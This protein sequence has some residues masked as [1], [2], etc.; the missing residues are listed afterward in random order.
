MRTIVDR[1]EG[2]GHSSYALQVL[3]YWASD[4]LLIS[5]RVANYVKRT[6][7]WQSAVLI[8]ATLDLN[9]MS[10]TFLRQFGR[11]CGLLD[12]DRL[13]D[14][15]REAVYNS[16]VDMG[17]GE[18]L[19][20][21]H[22]SWEDEDEDS[23]PEGEK[24]FDERNKSS[25]YDD[26][27]GFR[28][29]RGDDEY[30][31]D[32]GLQDNIDDGEVDLSMHSGIRGASDASTM[33]Q[34]DSSAD[35]DYRNRPRVRSMRQIRDLDFGRDPEFDGDPYQDAAFDEGI[36]ADDLDDNHQDG[37]E[38]PDSDKSKHR[39]ERVEEDSNGYSSFDDEGYDAD[40][41]IQEAECSDTE[42]R[43]HDSDIEAFENDASGAEDENGDDDFGENDED[44]YGDSGNDS[45]DDYEHG[46]D[47]F[48][49]SDDGDDFED[50]DDYYDN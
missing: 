47:D 37:K 42:H 32:Q 9:E 31:E 49:F 38:Y 34:H 50:S 25:D 33:R 19:Y 21:D 46:I 26:E 43:A 23:W 22:Y 1:L 13:D 16:P 6:R 24:E 20:D 44:D 2:L 27:K 5:E 45:Y 48:G 4:G 17:R 35:M 40:R 36:E 41:P 29:L 28:S 7:R 3:F 39:T 11:D 18:Q 15:L 12:V 10:Q 30:C 8:A 14:A